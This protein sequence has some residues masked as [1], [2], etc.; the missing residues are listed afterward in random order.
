M[1]TLH[2]EIDAMSEPIKVIA[3]TSPRQRE[4]FI[5]LPWRLGLYANDPA[6][7]PPLIRDQRVLFHPDKGY[8]FETGVAQ[9]FLAYRRGRPVG[10]ISAH[11]NSL[12]EAKYD[13][14]TGFF[15]FLECGND[16][17][18][19]GA[20]I[21]QAEQWLKLW[22]KTR[23]QGPQSFSIYDQ[24]GFEVFGAE[25]MPPVGLTHSAGYYADLVEDLGF[26]K[27]VDWHCLVVR[28]SAAYDAY[29][30]DVRNRILPAQDG[31]Q[32]RYFSKKE[33]RQRSRDIHEI[34]NQAWR[35][36][37]GHLDLT[38]KQITMLI[39]ELKLIA[40]PELTIF[41]EK[42]GQTIGFIISLPDMNPGLRRLNGRLYPWR[43]PHLLIQRKRTD[44][45]RTII[46]GVLPEFRGQHIDDVFYLMTIE[47]GCRLGY[48]EAD[49]SLIVETNRLMLKALKPLGA[50]IYKTY[51]IYE[52]PIH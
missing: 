47:N 16:A 22:G 38:H 40:I 48:T 44:R 11:V 29:L 42:G 34:F 20:L 1:L 15:G 9:L 46:M 18:V 3:V 26:V 7:V 36:N 25:V 13:R 30:A 37:W 50:E 45:L 51:R 2:L 21:G 6:W 27:R 28:K 52:K 14:K 10:R 49:C 17:A 39:D 31:I 33:L 43:I 24:V 19:A 5:K 41:A 35:R 12:Y 8:F 32:Y 23:I 4:I